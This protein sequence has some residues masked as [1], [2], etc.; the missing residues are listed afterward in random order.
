MAFLIAYPLMLLVAAAAHGLIPGAGLLG[1]LPV[2]PDEVAGLLLMLGGLLPAT[3]Y[4]TWATEGRS[5]IVRLLR[6]VTR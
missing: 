3:L 2:P 6:R 1:R 5:G 4:V